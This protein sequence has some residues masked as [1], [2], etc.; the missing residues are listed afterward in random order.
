MSGASQQG[1]GNP[2]HSLSASS[3][4]SSSFLSSAAAR[5]GPAHLQYRPHRGPGLSV[6]ALRDRDREH[7]ERHGYASADGNIDDDGDNGDG[8]RLGRGH[9]TGLGSSRIVDK[10]ERILADPGATLPPTTTTTGG[11]ILSQSSR[12]AAAAVAAE[13]AILE[14]R[15]ADESTIRSLQHRV[16][17]LAGDLTRAYAANEELQ[18]AVARERGRREADQREHLRLEQECVKWEREAHT[19]RNWGSEAQNA[20][21][22]EREGREQ[23]TETGRQREAA[24]IEASEARNLELVRCAG[25][26]S[27][28]VLGLSQCFFVLLLHP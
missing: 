15:E 26:F 24:A 25:F 3:T 6:A 4:S 2:N 12:T 21:I 7:P 5:G 1:H 19:L 9:K 11:A 23:A 14:R 20:A 17:S 18:R 22:R 13:E 28:R 10:L 16:A 8:T 27:M